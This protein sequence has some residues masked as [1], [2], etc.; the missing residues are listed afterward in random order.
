MYTNIESLQQKE[1]FRYFIELSGIPHPSGHEEKA[2]EW[3]LSYA[4]KW[5]REYKEDA[6]GNIVVY[7]PA[8]TTALEQ[9]PLC[10][11]QSH[12]DMVCEKDAEISIDFLQEGL[13]LEIIT[14]PNTQD[15]S[16]KH[17][18]KEKEAQWLHAVGT[19]LGADNGIA[20]AMA[21][22]LM[23]I[24]CPIQHGPLELLFTIEE[25]IGLTGAAH[26]GKDMIHAKYLLNIDNSEE[27]FFCTGC[28]G[29]KDFVSSIPIATTSI[30]STAYKAYTL[31]VEGL[32][33]GHSGMEI[34]DGRGNALK[35]IEWVLSEIQEQH[36]LHIVSIEGGDKRNAIPRFAQIQCWIK[37]S[38]A[39]NIQTVIQHCLE[40]IILE[41]PD[42]DK[43][44]RISLYENNAIDNRNVFSTRSCNRILQ[45][46]RLCPT[47]VLYRKGLESIDST[48][49]N[50]LASI[51]TIRGTVKIVNNCRFLSTVAE[52]HLTRIFNSIFS[53]DD[54][55]TVTENSY[56]AWS[57]TPT[58]RLLSFFIEEYKKIYHH[59]PIVAPV[60]AG[61]ECAILNTRVT[62]E[63]DMI[64]FGP[65][66]QYL[67]SPMERIHIESTFRVWEF[68]K[69]TLPL[70]YTI[71]Q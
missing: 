32:S 1:V 58:S 43:D 61:I 12:L 69:K 13:Q 65:D 49:S 45:L 71:E 66:I 21:M 36:E 33:G 4:K 2:K 67:H 24:E 17:D 8:N 16:N 29:G 19:T 5:K 62:H 59:A 41:L 57:P 28:A 26:L 3:V 22:E 25:E 7:I 18:N 48:M 10:A 54:I 47:G 68:I 31:T 30:Q 55:H 60:H 46:L 6:Y 38:D 56:P 39:D 9:A 42:K 11:I 37:A 63:L 70:L 35:I 51:Q 52:K 27:G 53:D 23:S 44:I 50:N 64:S 15:I 20:V 34:Y 14:V 40:N